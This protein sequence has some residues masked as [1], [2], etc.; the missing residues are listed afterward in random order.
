[1]VTDGCD[2]EELKNKCLTF[3]GAQ[4]HLKILSWWNEI[5]SILGEQQ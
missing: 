1:M 3:Q 4:E 2:M 5:N